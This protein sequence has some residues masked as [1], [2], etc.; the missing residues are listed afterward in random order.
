V[1]IYFGCT[2][3]S[4]FFPTP[5]SSLFPFEMLTNR[6]P[7]STPDPLAVFTDP[8]PDETNEQRELREAKEAEEKRVSDEIDEGIRKDKA[9]MKKEKDLVVK[10]LLLGQSESG[11][12][13]TLKSRFCSSCSVLTVLGVELTELCYLKISV[14]GML[15]K[16]GKRNGRPG[17]Q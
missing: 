17:E 11:K 13:T 8:P 7:H 6:A 16:H 10:V 1:Y 15:G 3:P 4:F 2:S 5:H 14:F 12:S 9:A